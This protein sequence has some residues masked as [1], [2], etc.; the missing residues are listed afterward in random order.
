MSIQK[1]INVAELFWGGGDGGE[2]ITHL[3]E[4]TLKR[5]PVERTET[6]N[7][8]GGQKSEILSKSNLWMSPDNDE[9]CAGHPKSDNRDIMIDDKEDEVI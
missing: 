6:S 7:G 9:E 1:F 4:R 2:G 5:V 8:E 3:N